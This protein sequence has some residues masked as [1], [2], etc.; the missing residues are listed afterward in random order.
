MPA[1][2]YSLPD[3]DAGTNFPAEMLTIHHKCGTIVDM[4]SLPVNVDVCLLKIFNTLIYEKDIGFEV[5]FYALG[6]GS[7]YGSGK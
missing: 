1:L 6:S 7:V 4:S 5:Y 3:R 2:F